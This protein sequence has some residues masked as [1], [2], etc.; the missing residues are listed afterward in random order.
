MTPG[1]R[2][3]FKKPVATPAVHKFLSPFCIFRVH[4]CVQN[5]PSLD[6]SQ[7]VEVSSQ[8]KTPKH[9]FNFVITQT[10]APKLL[11]C[12]NHFS[13]SYTDVLYGFLNSS[14]WSKMFRPL[15][16]PLGYFLYS[17]FFSLFSKYFPHYSV[18]KQHQTMFFLKFSNHE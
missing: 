6:F 2:I 4:F 14:I 9:T 7:R 16:P 15:H 18:L 13:T 11:N 12:S 5:S 3:L 10:P 1:S 8:S 17:Y